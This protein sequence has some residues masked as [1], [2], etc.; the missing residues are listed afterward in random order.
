MYTLRGLHQ[1]HRVNQE[2]QIQIRYRFNSEVTDSKAFLTTARD[3]VDQLIMAMEIPAGAAVEVIHDETD[4]MS[5]FYFLIGVAF[6]LIYMILAS[7]FESLIN[8]FII[9]FTIP[10]RGDW[11]AL[12]NNIYREFTSEREYAAGLF[13]SVRDCC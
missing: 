4:F 5:D 3:E 13:N 6:I 10:T 12:G 7:V 1:F 11:R 2:R 8:P 9:M